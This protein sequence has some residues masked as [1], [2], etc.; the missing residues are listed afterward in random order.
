MHLFISLLLLVIKEVTTKT[1]GSK[2]TVIMNNTGVCEQNHF[3]YMGLGHATRQQKLQSS[4][5]WYLGV[6]TLPWSSRL[7]QTLLFTQISPTRA[8]ARSH[9]VEG[10]HADLDLNRFVVGSRGR[11][12]EGRSI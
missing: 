11:E 12:V 1:M 4:L 2:Q 10:L 8:C 7:L 5:R 3:F 6:N 9:D